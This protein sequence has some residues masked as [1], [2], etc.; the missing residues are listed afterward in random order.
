[1]NED[2][3]LNAAAVSLSPAIAPACPKAGALAGA[4]CW[5]EWQE[6]QDVT[7]APKTAQ[8]A[9]KGGPAERG[10]AS[11]AA[12][13]APKRPKARAASGSTKTKGKK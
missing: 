6:Q 8:P 7:P 12:S 10:K 2:E 13:P 1:M 3:P 9:A 4:F 11:K 5:S